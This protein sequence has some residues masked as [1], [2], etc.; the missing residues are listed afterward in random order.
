MMMIKSLIFARE[1]HPKASTQPA[2][3]VIEAGTM[4]RAL[5]A[6]GPA[7]VVP[8]FLPPRLSSL[9]MIARMTTLTIRHEM[10]AVGKKGC[11]VCGT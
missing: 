4:T 5:A 9:V 7:S 6:I 3:L 2:R 8:R 10:V 1:L 11:A